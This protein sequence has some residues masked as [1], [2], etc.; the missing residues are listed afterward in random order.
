MSPSHSTLAGVF[1]AWLAIAVHASASANVITDWDE[2]A[3][4]VVMP[5]GTVGV[6]Q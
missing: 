5:A 2:K 3:V 1:G 6:S 4:A